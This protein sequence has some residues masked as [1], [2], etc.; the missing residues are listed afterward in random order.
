MQEGTKMLYP[1]STL[2]MEKNRYR[3]RNGCILPKSL[4]EKRCSG[5][6]K[7]C[8]FTKAIIESSTQWSTTVAAYL[9]YISSGSQRSYVLFNGS[10]PLGPDG[11]S[12]EFSRKAGIW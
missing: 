3:K 11:F 2:Q 1:F 5:D 7:V 9:N 10:K 4:E 12:A 6:G 8:G